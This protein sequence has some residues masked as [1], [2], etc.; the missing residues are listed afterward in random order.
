MAAAH[1]PATVER[2]P[3]LLSTLAAEVR[4]CA[5]CPVDTHMQACAE[6]GW[7]PFES[8]MPLRCSLTPHVSSNQH[9]A[10]LDF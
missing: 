3:E 5:P 8:L 4:A 7:L 1:R 2:S 9:F 10:A 6:L